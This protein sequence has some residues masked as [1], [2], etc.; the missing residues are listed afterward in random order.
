MSQ[1]YLTRILIET[2]SPLAI[3]SGGRETG[4]DGQ[5]ARDANQLPYIP[6]TS[7]AGVW[8]HLVDSLLGKEVSKHWFGC[9]DTDGES[10]RLFIQDGLLLD[11]QGSP[12]HGLLD[13]DSIPTDPLLQR[14]QQSRPHHRERV[15][16]NDRGV[17]S[18][19]SKFDQIML[20][21]GIRF[22]IDIRWQND[23]VSET[24]LKEWQQLLACFAHPA[25]ALGSSTRNGLGRFKI[26]AD[27][28]NT[29]TLSNNP[30]AG[31]ALRKF[32]Q[33]K[34]MPTKACIHISDTRP[35]AKLELTGLNGWCS[36]QGSRP[37]GEEADQHTDSFTYS[38]P[39]VSWHQGVARWSEKPEAILC[40]SSIKGILAHRL[41]FHYR[42]RTGQYAENMAEAS[43]KDWERRPEELDKLLG[44]AN[45]KI[46]GQDQAGLLFVD[47]AVIVYHKTL[48]RTHNSI[49]RFTGGVRQGA[50]YSEELLW[51]PKI[52]LTLQLPKNACISQYLAD[53]LADTLEDL[54]LGLLA[55]GAGSGRGNSLV[56]HKT[57]QSWDIDWSQLSIQAQE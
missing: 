51:Q 56:E 23:A 54:K 47:D 42:R 21:K 22:C 39:R 14:L 53:A 31:D 41:A 6:A 48:N 3:N 38:E 57:G 35:F 24:E 27:E 8:R 52:E 28:Q 36:G 13:A 40:G 26:V 33:R 10:S 55:L 25:F 45:E 2:T 9:I 29:L 50:L 7:L 12:V 15:R 49:D 34:T 20:P 18:D 4:F 32:V 44:S 30:N 37:L 16:I 19:L 5:L 43:H 17:A 46:S 1:L 11:S